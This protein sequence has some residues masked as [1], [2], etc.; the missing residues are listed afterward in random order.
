MYQPGEDTSLYFNWANAFTPN[1]FGG[2]SRTGEAFEPE[3]GEQF[4]IGIKQEF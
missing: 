2:R 1:I 3:R 4:E